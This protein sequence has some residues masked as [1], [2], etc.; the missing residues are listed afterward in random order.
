VCLP[1]ENFIGAPWTSRITEA[2][3]CLNSHWLLSEKVD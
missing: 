2:V 3:E 1:I